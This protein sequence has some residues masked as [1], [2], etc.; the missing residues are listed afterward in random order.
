MCVWSCFMAVQELL[1]PVYPN[2]GKIL[3]VQVK[4]SIVSIGLRVIGPVLL[5]SIAHPN[6]LCP[7]Y[8]CQIAIVRNLCWVC[9]YLISI[10]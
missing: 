4:S 6:F 3:V 10:H 1:S 2:T 7:I 9:N 5:V 8:C